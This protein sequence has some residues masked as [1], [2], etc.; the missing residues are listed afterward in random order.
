MCIQKTVLA[1]EIITQIFTYVAPIH[2][3]GKSTVFRHN[4]STCF[5]KSL[6]NPRID[7][8]LLFLNLILPLSPIYLC[9]RIIPL[10]FIPR[11]SSSLAVFFFKKHPPFLFLRS[12]LFP[13]VSRLFLSYES[14]GVSYIHGTFQPLK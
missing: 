3:L 8:L 4:S 11:F 9:N 13:F 7:I 12:L 14:F 5:N 1:G 6:V 2:C 10:V